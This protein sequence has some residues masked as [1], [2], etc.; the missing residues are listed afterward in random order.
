MAHRYQVWLTG[1]VLLLQQTNR[2]RTVLG[3][4]PPGMT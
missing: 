1:L 3:R 2:A 4:A